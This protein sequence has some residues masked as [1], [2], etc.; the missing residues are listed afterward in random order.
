M[1]AI[2]GFG[3]M[4]RAVADFW[5]ESAVVI[6]PDERKWRADGNLYVHNV[7][8]LSEVPEVIIDFSSH[9]SIGALTGY[10]AAH[11]VPLVV[12]TTG[13]T[14]PERA[15]IT[16][17]SRVI[18]VYWAP[19]TSV[20]MVG[21]VEAC[22]NVLAAMPHA[23]VSV[24]EIH[25]IGKADAPSGTA[26]WLADTLTAECGRAVPIT[27]ERVGDTSGTHEVRVE[28][29]GQCVVLRHVAKSRAIFAEGALRAAQ[30]LLHRPA[31]L[32]GPEDLKV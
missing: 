20:G 8:S 18:P 10:A 16:E 9:A 1:I 31:G 11:G 30:W 6:E 2:S 14:P 29:E 28:D 24:H 4:G 23:D 7:Q 32:Y 3:R 27:C 17:A 21:F 13:H 12:A 25:R 19:N 26:L 15:C 22:R 5:A